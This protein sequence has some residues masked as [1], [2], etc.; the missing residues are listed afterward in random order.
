VQQTSVDLLLSITKEQLDAEAKAPWG[1]MVTVRYLIE[2]L[3][4]HDQ[5]HR[6]QVHFLITLLRGLPEFEPVP[7]GINFG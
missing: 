2:D 3:F 7:D 6:G 4:D 5:F 1:E